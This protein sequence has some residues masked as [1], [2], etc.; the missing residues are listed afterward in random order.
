MTGSQSLLFGEAWRR[1]G[2]QPRTPTAS[3]A[4]ASSGVIV[5]TRAPSPRVAGTRPQRQDIKLNGD[6]PS[7]GDATGMTISEQVVPAA[8]SESPPTL[9][10][11]LGDA[12]DFARAQ[13]LFKDAGFTEERICRELGI[14]NVA[15]IAKVFR[16]GPDRAAALESPVLG[17]LLRVFTFTQTVPRN[18]V[19]RA[20][21][22]SALD[23]L[24]ALDL[25]R[26]GRFDSVAAGLE[27]VYYSPV[28]LYPV[29]GFVIASDRH[30]NPDGSPLALP[31]DVVFPAID[32]GTLRFLGLLPRR[33][34][35]EALD[36]C[37]GTGIGALVLSRHVQRVIAADITP[38]ATHFTQFNVL[39]NGRSNVEVVQG[40]LFEAV[41][42]RTFD[43]IVAHPPYVPAVTDRH[44]F[45]DAGE[46]GERVLRRIVADLP[47]YLRPRGTFY[48]LTAAWDSAEG[49]L[50]S[51]IRHWLGER[52][53]E[54]DVL[55][56][57]QES[58]APERVA[59]WLADKSDA[60][61]P[62]ARVLWEQ[63]FR[64]AGLERNVYGAIVLRRRDERD[65]SAGGQP[66]TERPRLGPRTDG[67]CLEWALR[68]HRWR[69]DQTASGTLSRALLD[70]RPELGARLRVR[71]THAPRD[72]SLQITEIVL[73]SDRPF[74]SATGIEPWMLKLVEGF[75]N[76]RTA[77]EVYD[78]AQAAGASPE[79]F[80][81]DHFA[82]L[83]A[84][85]VERGY[86]EIKEAMLEGA[87]GWVAAQRTR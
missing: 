82:T 19:E 1:A 51:R 35:E 9:P 25:L 49:P 74:R 17:V 86:V 46:T 5:A 27:D 11:R 80:G 28:Y 8:G 87:T 7:A 68:W 64:E 77:R 78:H 73:E 37:S 56:A 62:E 52:E 67:A 29:A 72:G 40:D 53:R 60:A 71:V 13:S 14:P 76:G 24:L 48:C 4:V 65:V 38:R 50:E 33:P 66:V 41:A 84:M 26:I 55:F 34:A 3:L 75:G 32:A 47:H 10:L 16:D 36:L 70:S 81:H 54:Y 59:G 45:R 85:M 57:E 21:E 39:L 43:R 15:L 20:V 12:A 69:A 79:A 42:G 61:A 18:E 22:R 31:P 83:V 23:S 58:V 6:T 44:V 63:H 30:D 2:G